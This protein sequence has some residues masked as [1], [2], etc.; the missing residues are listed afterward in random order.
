[1][2]KQKNKINL[3]GYFP[4][5][6]A[7]GYN[8]NNVFRIVGRGLAPR[9]RRGLS[10]ATARVAPTIL[11]FL[12]CFISSVYSQ[13]IDPEVKITKDLTVYGA[14]TASQSLVV[15][16]NFGVGTDGALT[17]SFTLEG[18]NFLQ[19]S[20][21]PTAVSSFAD[22]GATLLDDSEWIQV[23]GNTLFISNNPAGSADD[24]ITIMDI[25]DP[26][27][28]VHLASLTDGGAGLFSSLHIFK[29]RG[30]Y[31]YAVSGTDDAFTVVDISNLSNPVIVGS[32]TD[33]TLLDGAT[34]IDV[35]GKYAYVGA[36]DSNIFTVIDI[37]DPQDPVITGFIADA[38]ATELAGAINVLV[39]FPYAYVS[40]YLDNGIEILDVSDPTNPA[41]V[42]SITDT[43]ATRLTG[44]GGLALHGQY[45]FVA[46]ILDSAIEVLDV[47]DPANPTHV[48]F[49]DD[50]ASTLFAIPS[51]ILI[52]GELSLCCFGN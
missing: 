43:G 47:S 16:G 35:V 38:G 1:M 17:E 36:Y 27:N 39:D 23:I 9:Q 40:G 42:G 13:T 6:K 25:A 2:I 26:E 24:G 41:H 34:G 46:A 21:A 5:R 32:V 10:W 15:H 7:R 37:S 22:T 45:L 3:L 14:L 8:L 18:G 44:A 19:T 28:P 52:R 4:G 20:S 33:A 11:L 49:L 48:T 31:L 12:F 50:S 29:V 30:K 51:N